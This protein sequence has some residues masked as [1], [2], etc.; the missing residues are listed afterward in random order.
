MKF[1]YLVGDATKPTGDGVKIICHV[2]NDIG[3]W[4]AGFV[5]GLNNTFGKE[6]DSP[7][8]KYLDWFKKGYY[9]HKNADIPF[10]L[11]EIQLVKV[12]PTTLV[13]NMIGQRNVGD[14]NGVPPIRYEAIRDCFINLRERIKPAMANGS[15]I[16]LAGPRFGAGLAGGDWTKIEGIV[17]DVLKDIDVTMKIYDLPQG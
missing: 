2:C 5:V 12:K 3:G 13:A 16:T 7:R 14:W 17:A 10:R 15:V 11:G 8:G 9:T 4:G 6:V 1:E